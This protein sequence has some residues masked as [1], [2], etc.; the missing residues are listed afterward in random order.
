[1][2]TRYKIAEQVVRIVSGGDISEDSSIDI[3]EVMALVDQERNALIKSEIMD[4]TYTKS[5]TTAKGELEINGAWLSH[6]DLQLGTDGAKN[7][8]VYASLNEL[9]STNYISLPNDMGIQRVASINSPFQKQSYKFEIKGVINKTTYV[10]KRTHIQFS[11]SP[12]ILDKK[13]SVSFDFKIQDSTMSD[14][15]TTQNMYDGIRTHKISFNVNTSGYGDYEHQNVNFVRAL[16]NS[17]GFKK[18]IKDFDISYQGSGSVQW[19]AYDDATPNLVDNDTQYYYNPELVLATKYQSTIENFKIN[20]IGDTLGGGANPLLSSNNDIGLGWK[21]SDSGSSA[22]DSG[23]VVTAGENSHGIMFIIN[24]TAYSVG[25]IAPETAVTYEDL[26]DKFIQLNADKIA[27]EQNIAVTKSLSNFSFYSLNFTEIEPKGGFKMD[28]VR[29][30]TA[31]QA[32]LMIPQVVDSSPAAGSY[33]TIIYTRMPS[34]GDHNS[35][36]NRTVNKTGRQFYYVES[37]YQGQ[38]RLYLYKKYNLDER[39]G[40]IRVSYIGTSEAISDHDPYPVP[41]D[42]EKIIIKNLVEMFSVMKQAQDDMTN[43]NID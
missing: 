42:Y 41:G 20:G 37:S 34:G 8:A 30:G 29:E 39:G 13:Y 32:E 25:F 27:R 15:V 7:G 43:D 40:Y 3:R 2:T 31:F 19:F 23:D 1:M 5:T 18:F 21:I 17:P 38:V 10:K 12:K 26:I 24:E 33:E 35:L 6:H 14:E 4:W 16:I 11:G 36:Y 9:L 28:V 22:N